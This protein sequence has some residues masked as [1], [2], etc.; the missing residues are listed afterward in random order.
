M[1]SLA[2]PAMSV[3]TAA[4]TRLLRLYLASRRTGYAVLAFAICAGGLH[5]LLHWTPVTGS[6]ATQ[7]PVLIVGAAAA[8]IGANA[9]SPFDE[10][11]QAT[12]R[13][14]PLLRLSSSIATTAVAYGA[15]AAGV[16]GAHLRVGAVGLLRDLTGV[17]GV[18]L[19]A[20]ALGSGNLAW[21]GT[22]SYLL[23]ALT[24]IAQAWTNPWL[25]PTRPSTDTGAAICAILT[26]AAGLAAITIRGTRENA[27]D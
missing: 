14:L 15:L 5:L 16:T 12:G 11:E 18:T 27:P 17:V 21:L 9:R 6:F 3:P 19:L 25:W 7:L 20:A 13:R 10:S 4:L 26:F 22:L 24:G 23:L 1:T 2:A 8:V